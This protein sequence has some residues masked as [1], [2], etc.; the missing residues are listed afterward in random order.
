MTTFCDNYHFDD[1]LVI[2]SNEIIKNGIESATIPD[3]IKDWLAGKIL[4]AIPEDLCKI[5]TKFMLE[6]RDSSKLEFDEKIVGKKLDLT[7]RVDKSFKASTSL[8]SSTQ[9]CDR[10][11][12]FDVNFLSDE[13][14]TCSE[15]LVPLL[16]KK[17]S[18]PSLVN[19]AASKFSISQLPGIS[20]PHSSH[21]ITKSK[22]YKYDS[23]VKN[24]TSMEHLD[25][26]EPHDS[27]ITVRRMKKAPKFSRY[28]KTVLNQ[29]NDTKYECK[30]CK[31]LFDDSGR[32]KRSPIR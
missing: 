17:S 31:K 27:F 3:S 28:G 26:A 29:D 15:P 24:I 20:V 10:K 32:L 12:G 18:V 11:N 6:S 7:I 9:V 16:E 13:I 5:L 21:A 14:V 25:N 1:L 4:R 22:K 30:D 2:C 19:D 8:N 23:E